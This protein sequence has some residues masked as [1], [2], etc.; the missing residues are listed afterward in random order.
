LATSVQIYAVLHERQ[1]R[2]GDPGKPVGI[3]VSVLTAALRIM[4][5]RMMDIP[6]EGDFLATA[7]N[8][9]AQNMGR[10]ETCV[11][12][13]PADA[14]WARDS[15]T[16]NAVGNL[17]LHLEGNVRQW[18]LS[19][20]GGASDRRDRSGEFSARLGAPAAGLLAAL[21][22]TVNESIEVLRALPHPRLTEVVSIQ[23]YD[24]TILAAIFHVVEH[25]SGH[26]FQIILLTKRATGEDLGFYSYL[27]KTGRK[28]ET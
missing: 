12:K 24:T 6:L 1:H 21:R 27:A 18:I 4:L 2:G 8:K 9:L 15:D 17:L 22:A 25:F 16:E 5:A 7:A 10:I 26:T 28:E 14:L 20:I 11:A 13:L 3:E 19:G 23:G